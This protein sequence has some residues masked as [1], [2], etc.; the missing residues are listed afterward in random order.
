MNSL[1]RIAEQ[2]ENMVEAAEDAELDAAISACTAGDEKEE[3]RETEGIFAAIEKNADVKED[4]DI[5]GFG[6]TGQEEYF[7]MQ[8]ITENGGGQ[9]DFNSVSEAAKKLASAARELEAVKKAADA[10]KYASAIASLEKAIQRKAQVLKTALADKTPSALDL[11]RDSTDRGEKEYGAYDKNEQVVKHET[12]DLDRHDWQEDKRDE[13]GFGIPR[14]AASRVAAAKA[15]RLATF[16]LGTKATD[17]MITAQGR[18]FYASLAPEF[19]DNALTRVSETAPLYDEEVK[20]EE[21]KESAKEEPVVASDSEEVKT[22]A[23]QEVVQEEATAEAEEAEEEKADEDPV[24]TAEDEEEIA[25]IAACLKARKA[26]LAAEAAKR[27]AAEEAEV[28]EPVKEE[29]PAEAPEAVAASEEADEIAEAQEEASEQAEQEEQKAEEIVA[30][31]EEEFEL[32]GAASL[33][34]EPDADLSEFFQ[35][36]KLEDSAPAEK[37]TASDKGKKRVASKLPRIPFIG[38]QADDDK[39][40]ASVWSRSTL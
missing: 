23:V 28:V 18:E 9:Q 7:S 27:V 20:E 5:S 17:E 31:D 39:V 16:L 21:V 25:K 35:I 4:F 40:L 14:A 3:E 13:T 29:A 10:F 24:F 33:D 19:L 12:K 30:E 11:G 22:E 34:A 32:G 2:L 15:I 6:S 36:E 38:E 1:I 37:I 26:V 8:G